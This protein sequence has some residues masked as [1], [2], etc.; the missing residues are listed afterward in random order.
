[1][2][3]NPTQ[4]IF[5]L[6][7]LSKSS[8]TCL[9]ASAASCRVAPARDPATSRAVVSDSRPHRLPST[10]SSLTR[11]AHSPA[12]SPFAARSFVVLS[13]R[14]ARLPTL[15]HQVPSLREEAQDG[16][17]SLL[18]SIR[19][20]CRRRGHL[21]P[22]PPSVQDRQVQRRQA[23]PEGRAHRHEGRPLSGLLLA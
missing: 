23:R 20:P 6:R 7:K 14:L 3:F 19:C 5:R 13:N 11:S 9:R 12:T 2:G 8:R 1:M 21:W 4:W 22:V 18:P 10:A 17:C 16:V 15:Y